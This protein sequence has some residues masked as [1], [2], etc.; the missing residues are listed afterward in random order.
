[1]TASRSALVPAPPRRAAVEVE[2]Y[3]SET[4]SEKACVECTT[5]VVSVGLT[6]RTTRRASTGS[7]S[8]A[9]LKKGSDA[10]TLA[11]SPSN[12]KRHAVTGL[13]C[14]FDKAASASCSGA[15][16]IWPAA[17]TSGGDPPNAEDHLGC[18]RTLPA[19]TSQSNSP[20]SVPSF[21]ARRQPPSSSGTSSFTMVEKT[22]L[23]MGEDELSPPPRMRP[24]QKVL[25]PL[26]AA[27]V[28]RGGVSSEGSAS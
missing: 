1:M 7:S 28:N 20:K 11:A 2:P 16:S 4:P 9:H 3:T 25:I 10:H 8:K 13:C 22:V 15:S 6:R 27:A 23:T 5:A 14:S 17:A 19:T 21:P 24:S 12:A 26:P 18:P